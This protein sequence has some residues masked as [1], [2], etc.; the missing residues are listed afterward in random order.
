VLLSSLLLSDARSRFVDLEYGARVLNGADR[1]VDVSD[2]LSGCSVV[3]VDARVRP[4]TRLTTTT[5]PFSFLPLVLVCR[6]KY[7]EKINQI[8]D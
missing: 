3:V 8:Y 5:F 4:R 2:D 6:Q 7:E 1:R